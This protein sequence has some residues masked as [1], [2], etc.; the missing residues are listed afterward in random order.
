MLERL[1]E[2]QQERM[3]DEFYGDDEQD[4]DLN[5][6]QLKINKLVRT[7]LNLDLDS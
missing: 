7:G 6:E 1:Y 2:I 5:A 4:G 3:I